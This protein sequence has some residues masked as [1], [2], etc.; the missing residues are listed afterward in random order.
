MKKM[1]TSVLCLVLVFSLSGCGTNVQSS[2]THDASY[3]EGYI[4][5]YEAGHHDGEQQNKKCF[6]Q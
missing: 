1:I 2:D 6:A 3:E 4:A 5:G